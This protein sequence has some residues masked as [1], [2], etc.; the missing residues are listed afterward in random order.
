MT[1]RRLLLLSLMMLPAVRGAG[2]QVRHLRVKETPLGRR[3]AGIVPQTFV[4][5]TAGRIAYAIRVPGGE[6]VVLDGVVG[7]TYA[8]IPRSRLTEAGLT[9]PLVFSTDGNRL[10][11][12][13]MRRKQAP[14]LR[15]GAGREAA[16]CDRGTRGGDLR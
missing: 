7:K 13:A 2:A 1:A 10:A 14:C 4:V 12:L 5:S 16:G 9:L 15:G 6:A 3:R 11:Y 8:S